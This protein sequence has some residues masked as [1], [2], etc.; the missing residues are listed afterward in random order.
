[1]SYLPLANI[2]HHKLRSTLGAL[3]IGMGIA[4]L[5]T[6][7]GLARGSLHEIADRWE[8]VDAELIVFPHAWGESAPDKSGAGLSDRIAGLI[9]ARH[10]DLVQRVVPVF[11]WPM[12]L[13]GQNQRVAGVDAG[14]WQTLTGGQ[15]LTQGRFCDPD[16]RFAKWIEEQLLGPAEDSQDLLEITAAELSDPAHNGL[17]IVIDTR[18]AKA[19]NYRLNQTVFAANHHWRIVGIVPAGAMARV[20]MPR[21]TAQYLF[22]DGQ[23]MRSTLMFAKL[24]PGVDAG[25]AARKIAETTGQDVVPTAGYRGMLVER[26]GV[27]FLYVDTVNAV[28]LIIAFLFVTVM[29]YTMVLQRT[30]EIA[31]LKAN[32]ASNA[33]ILRQVLAES[34]LLT[35]AGAGAGI[36]MSF[37][38]ARLIEAAK[39]L[40]TVTIT[41]PWIG[42]AVAAAACGALVS[43]IYPAWRATRVDTLA[44]LAFE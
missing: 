26:Y 17:E 19:G 37:V 35:G 15:E 25:P 23:I 11:I 36:A 1:M 32:G 27:M 4:M 10:G 22:A 14:D 29:L 16:G 43:A 39:P 5:V 13:G 18:L 33:F 12:K 20:F 8:S 2:M 34:F 7:S 42:I 24:K 38:A 9:S 3:G 41:W 6:L 40:L 31:I 28:A 21:R 44:A 30:R